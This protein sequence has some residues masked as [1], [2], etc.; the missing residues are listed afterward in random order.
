M[1][2]RLFIIAPTKKKKDCRDISI[3]NHWPDYHSAIPV[4]ETAHR[5]FNV[6][7]MKMCRFFT[8]S[9]SHHRRSHLFFEHKTRKNKYISTDLMTKRSQENF[10]TIFQS[11]LSRLALQNCEELKIFH[12]IMRS[13]RRSSNERLKSCSNFR[14]VNLKEFLFPFFS[15]FLFRTSLHTIKSFFL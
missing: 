8:F 11:R 7:T 1:V 9:F 12:Y 5:Q 2:L 4:L 15:F 3:I 6:S 14:N 10:L 13:G